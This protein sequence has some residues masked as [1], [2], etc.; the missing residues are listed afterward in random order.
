MTAD[1]EAWSAVPLILVLQ[2]RNLV[3]VT[4]SWLGV[5]SLSRAGWDHGFQLWGLGSRV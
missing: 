2:P 1:L 4:A 5:S 3:G